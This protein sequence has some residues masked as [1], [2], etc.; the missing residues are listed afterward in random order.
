MS[1]TQ[2]FDKISVGDAVSGRPFAVSRETIREF[3]EGSLDFNPLHFDE[4]YMK[5]TFGKTAFRDVI[6]HGMQNFALM[7]RTVTDWLLPKGGYHRRLEARWLN[8]VY[9]GDVI[10]PNARVSPKN[11]TDKGRW[12]LFDVEIANQDGLVVA[13]GE[14]M[15]EFPDVMPGA[16]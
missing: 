2:E 5:S 7:T 1:A 13:R 9:P 15:A 10:T 11:V 12:L 6:M 3:A 14:A 8:P 4:E 16:R